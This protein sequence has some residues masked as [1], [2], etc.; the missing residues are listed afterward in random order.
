MKLS[1]ITIQNEIKYL[2]DDM[3]IGL[4]YSNRSELD[5]EMLL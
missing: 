1:N 3:V 4:L 2:I 5:S